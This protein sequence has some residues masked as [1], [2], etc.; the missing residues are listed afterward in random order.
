MENKMENNKGLGIF[1]VLGIVFVILKLCSVINWSWW[2]VLLPFYGGF[3]F[4][5]TIIFIL[6][7]IASSNN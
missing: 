3:L 5:F 1:G 6:T 2:L 4:I 7:I